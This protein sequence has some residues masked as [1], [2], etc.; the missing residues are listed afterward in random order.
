MKAITDLLPLAIGIAVIGGVTWFLLDRGWAAGPWLLAALLFGHGWVHMMFVFPKPAADASA[1]GPEWPF[2]MTRSWLVTGA[3]L[4]VGVVRMVG[5]VLMVL[6]FV[7]FVLG[8][9]STVGVLVPVGWWATLVIAAAI[10]ST[11]F[12][13]L[14]FSPALLL[15]FAINVA[16]LWLVTA[17]IWSPTRPGLTG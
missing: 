2:D 15:G 3:G 16:A 8:A 12:L 10:G 4:D 14:F 11:L 9:L 13:A 1:G 5:L 17:S 7:A 6:V